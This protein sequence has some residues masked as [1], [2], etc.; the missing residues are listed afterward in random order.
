MLRTY[1]PPE[2]R[3]ALPSIPCLPCRRWLCL[4][5]FFGELLRGHSIRRIELLSTEDVDSSQSDRIVISLGCQTTEV[6][7]ST[8]TLIRMGEK[9]GKAGP[10]GSYYKRLRKA[11][12]AVNRPYDGALP[13]TY[14]LI[15][16]RVLDSSCMKGP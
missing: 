5:S 8:L 11:S 7:P 13:F 4:G 10:P 14:L 9:H 3:S 6:D 12:K 2:L 16:D 15:R 1:A